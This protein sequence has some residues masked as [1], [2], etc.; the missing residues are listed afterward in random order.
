METKTYSV[1]GMTCEHCVMHVKKALEQVEGV[2]QVEVSLEKNQATIT[3]DD[4]FQFS[5]AQK[6]VSE[7]GYQLLT[8]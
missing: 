8:N 1:K 2:H 7:A 5:E 3:F 4:R 6:A